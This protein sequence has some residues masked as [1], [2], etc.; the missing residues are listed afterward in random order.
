M[1]HRL[2]LIFLLLGGCSS[3]G[4]PPHLQ[5]EGLVESS[6]LVQSHRDPQVFWTHNDS[7]GEGCP[8]DNRLFAVDRAG[9]SLGT[10]VVEGACNID[11]EDLAIDN[12]GFLYIAD[13][14]NNKS[15]R[16]DLVIYR[17]PEPSPASG[18]VSTDRRIPFSYAE[19]RSFPAA[20]RSFDAESLFWAPHPTTRVGTLYLLTKHRD[21]D[22]TVLYRFEDLSGAQ[23]TPTRMSTFKLG[24]DPDRY[25]GMATAADATPNG[26]LLAVLSYHALF[27]FE[28][29]SAGDDYLAHP[30]ARVDF[31]Q[32]VTQQCEAV[33]W[34]G[35]AAVIVTNE[36]GRIFR[37]ENPT[38]S[39]RWP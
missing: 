16:Q 14:G 7:S 25:G 9:R 38:I 36:D 18:T 29:P 39:R 23:T 8:G 12:A 2:T 19:Q 1:A 5:V 32:D 22:E 27:I 10:V 35:T 31:D 13:F 17:L 37:I 15:A 34:D 24:G 30:V 21:D 11:W 3:C 6:G 26:N 33:A 28:R 20:T 4:A